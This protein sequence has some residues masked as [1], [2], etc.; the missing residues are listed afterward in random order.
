MDPREFILS[1]RMLMK[2]GGAALIGSGAWNIANPLRAKAASKKSP[3]GTAR[4][5]IFMELGGAMS[6]TDGFDFKEN[7]GNPPDLDA[8]KVTSDLFLSR[9]LFPRTLAFADKL[10]IARTIRS[11]EEV[12]FRGQYYTQAG[13]PFSPA[14]AREI[15]PVSSVVSME[16]EAQRREDD[17]FPTACGLGL[18]GSRAGVIPPGFLPSRFSTM[19]ISPDSGLNSMSF[20]QSLGEQLTERWDLLSELSEATTGKNALMGKDMSQYRDFFHYAYRML[21]DPRWTA[22]LQLT[23]ED[24]K[25]YGA[26]NFGNGAILARNLIA[27][28]AG[29]RYCHIYSGGWDQHSDIWKPKGGHYA[30]CAMF[31][32]AFSSLVEDLSTMPAKVTPGKTLLDETLVVVMGE[33]GRTPGALNWV[34]G[35]DHWNKTF[36]AVFIG[37]GIA[38]GR[39]VGKTDSQG[40]FPAEMGWDHKDQPWIEN[41]YASIYSALGIDWGKS[42]D[43]TWSGRT[44]FYIDPIQQTV[45]LND[46]ALPIF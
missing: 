1:R 21:K 13:R 16:L 43:G 35:R 41:V 18:E 39:I 5:L 24:K 19:D 4:N 36:P 30:N 37:G 7:A 3:K 20:D 44:F 38:P 33:F 22:A 25:R 23:D 31:D 15:P 40:R 8:V 27:A 12:H 6:H 10:T 17:S 2:L 32:S 34:K 9:R 45:M 11:N 29:T 28:N 42:L 46:D 14:F 26:T